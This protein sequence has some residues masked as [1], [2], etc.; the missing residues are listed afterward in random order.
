MGYTTRF[1][2]QIAVEPPFNEHEISY[3]GKLSGTRRMLRTKGPYY[4]E[5]TGFMGQDKEA[6][7]LDYNYPDPSQP[8]LWCHWSAN[9]AGDI[10]W[11]ESEKFYYSVEWMKYVIS[12]FN[13]QEG[14]PMQ[15]T[16][17]IPAEFQH[18]T[19]HSFNGVI[20]AQGEETGDH[21]FLIVTNSMVTVQTAAEFF[22]AKV[23]T[24][25]LL[26]LPMDPDSNDPGA[27]TVRQYLKAFLRATWE[28]S[29]KRPFG[30]SGWYDEI[31]QPFVEA[32]ML[33]EDWSHTD[34]D[35]LIY[36]AIEAL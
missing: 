5:G 8:G 31:A 22:G 14:L 19:E 35:D 33:D 2:G 12:L 16:W 17:V 23:P 30:N 20:E 9:E 18:F 32:G 10:S 24:S 36:Q 1:S 4:V 21:W 28:D 11:D 25:A 3:L 13:N 29:P 27:S 26:D 15:D 6:D 34:V 7:V